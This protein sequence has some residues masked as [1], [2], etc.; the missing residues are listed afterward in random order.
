MADV[1]RSDDGRT[2]PPRRRGRPDEG[3]RDK[4]VQAAT[5]LFIEHRYDDVATDDILRRAGVSRGAMYHHFATKLDLFEA[6][7]EAGE[8]ELLGDFVVLMGEVTSPYDGLVRSAQAYLVLCERSPYLRHVGL[9]Q[10]RTVLGWDRWRQAA[11]RHGLGLVIAMVQA[12]MDAGELAPR[13]PALT[14]QLLLAA[15]IEAALLVLAADDPAAVRPQAEELVCSHLAGLRTGE[16][17]PSA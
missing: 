5:E 2:A 7:Y 17:S 14:G 10:A 6:V 12:A 15:L 16:A 4:L 13:D 3:A 8:S 9:G 1:K 11:M